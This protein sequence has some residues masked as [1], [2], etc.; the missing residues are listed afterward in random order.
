MRLPAICG[1]LYKSHNSGGRG[2]QDLMVSYFRN[3]KI[4]GWLISQE[5]IRGR[6][7]RRRSIVGEWPLHPSRLDEG[8]C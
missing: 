1:S 8:I 5:T 2:A 7:F 4:V 3:T 6:A